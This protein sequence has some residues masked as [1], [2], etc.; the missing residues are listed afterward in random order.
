[1]FNAG[2]NFLPEILEDSGDLQILL[3]S[4]NNLDVFAYMF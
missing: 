1:M 2:N 3:V 4:L